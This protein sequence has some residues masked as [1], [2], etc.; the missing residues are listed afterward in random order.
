MDVREEEEGRSEGRSVMERIGVA[1]AGN[2][3]PRENERTSIW[4]FITRDLG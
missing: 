3:T 4:A 1:P 2:I